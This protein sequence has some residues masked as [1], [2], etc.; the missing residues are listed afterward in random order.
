MAIGKT[1]A[2]YHDG[3]W[4]DGNV[5]I[6][7][8]A[9]HASWLGT[10]I[11]DGARKFDGATPDLDLHC[12]RLVRSAEV[13]G[14]VSPVSAEEIEA[15]VRKGL[16]RFARDAT[17]YIRPMMW[18][19]DGG[20][21]VLDLDP[22]STSFAICIEDMPMPKVGAYSLTVSPYRRPRP[23]MAI[24]GAKTGSLYPNNGRILKDARAR[25]YSNA[26]SLDAYGNV[27][28]TASMNVFAV[29]DGVVFTPVPNGCFL[30]GLTRQ[31]VIGLLRHDGV[32]VIEAT[33]SLADF[34]EADEIFLT[35]N[36]AKVMPVNRYQGRRLD[37][38][39]VARRARS[40]YWDFAR[41]TVASV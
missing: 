2:T 35:G 22:E 28:E 39:P 11:F 1:I 23:D 3:R 20:T 10:Q 7:R 6:M 19:R 5:P 26:L 32:D 25:G 40:L 15:Q 4:F 14:M 21:G 24:T 9:D 27:A 36:I 31:R 30:D 38:G 33:M 18:S 17:L 34:D 8:A 29:K 12:A 16:D 41:S 37:T 13:M